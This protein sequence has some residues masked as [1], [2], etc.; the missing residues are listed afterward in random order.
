MPPFVHG[1]FRVNLALLAAICGGLAASVV[2]PSAAEAATACQSSVLSQAA[3]AGS[4]WAPFS[5]GSAFTT[6]LS[7]DPPLAGDNSAVR[8]HIASYGWTLGY[9]VSG[10]SIGAGSRPVF[11]ASPSDPTMTIHCT[12]VFGPGSCQGANGVDIN[13]ARIHVPAGARAENN[14]DAHMTIIETATG[15]EYDFWRASVSQGTITSATGAETNVSTGT[16]TGG[17]GDAANLPLSAGLLRPSE[18]ISGQIDHPL[19]VVVPCTNAT[20]ADVGYTWPATGGWGEHCGQYWNEQA[21]TAPKLG[22]L[23]RLDM[24]AAQIAASRAP[25]WEQTIMTALADYGAYIEDTDGSWHNEGIYIL[26]QASASWTDIGQADQWNAA[27]R[28]FGQRGDTLRSNVP[29]PATDLELVDTCVTQG[30]CS[31]TG[32]PTRNSVSTST[33]RHRSPRARLRASRR[34]ARLWRP[35]HRRAARRR[36]RRHRRHLAHRSAHRHHRG[37]RHRGHHRRTRHTRRHRRR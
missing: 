9:E 24:T 6:R 19:V 34:A 16:G 28:A 11:Y 25:R 33:S 22:Q 36:A 29:I 27:A 32:G 14:S 8:Q 15:A 18:L 1:S 26:T 3:S 4:C 12:S 23:M 37:R 21:S 30:R 20:G 31:A 7:S 2:A 13:G 35:R 10:F 17:G 5:S